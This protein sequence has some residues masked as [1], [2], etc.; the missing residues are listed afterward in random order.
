M[1]RSLQRRRLWSAYSV[2]GSPL[3]E[4]IYNPKTV[5]PLTNDNHLAFTG[6]AFMKQVRPRHIPIYFT[7]TTLVDYCRIVNHNFI[8]LIG[9]SNFWA[10]TETAIVF[11]HLSALLF[12]G[13][14][15]YGSYLITAMIPSADVPAKS[16]MGITDYIMMTAAMGSTSMISLGGVLGVFALMYYLGRRYFASPLG[17]FVVGLPGV[18]LIPYVHQKYRLPSALSFCP[19]PRFFYLKRFIIRQSN[20]SHYYFYFYS[21][22]SLLYRC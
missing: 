6:L 5:P 2:S 11:I 16:T 15:S 12:C 10:G 9:V 18:R 7:S 14:L 22:N 3:G 1:D 13:A 8:Y 19:R 21:L 20:L 17:Q 4:S